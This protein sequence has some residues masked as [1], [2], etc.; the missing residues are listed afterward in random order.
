MLW[1]S[2]VFE[3]VFS[4]KSVLWKAICPH[5]L[6]YLK[7][8]LRIYWNAIVFVSVDN[9]V[10]HHSSGFYNVDFL[11]FLFLLKSQSAVNEL[12]HC[13]PGAQAA[14]KLGSLVSALP[15][16]AA[17][18][19]DHPLSLQKPHSFAPIIPQTD[20]PTALLRALKELAEV[21]T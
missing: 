3:G 15:E 21:C 6:L 18:A 9:L 12:R 13:V 16:R 1:K 20:D 2:R 4:S 8:P 7:E 14:S 10:D 5:S 19:N 17:H 11:L